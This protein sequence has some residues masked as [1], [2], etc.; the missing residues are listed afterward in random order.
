[1][2]YGSDFI[3]IG[4]AMLALAFFMWYAITGATKGKEPGEQPDQN[5]HKKRREEAD[6]SRVSVP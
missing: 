3:V 2:F 5:Q 1:M 6:R 4:M